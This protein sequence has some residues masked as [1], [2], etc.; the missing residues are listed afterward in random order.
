ME[1]NQFRKGWV[2]F[3][4]PLFPVIERKMN[5]AKR[6]LGKKFDSLKDNTSGTPGKE[7]HRDTGPYNLH[8]SQAVV[9]LKSP[10]TFH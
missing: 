2:G 10:K 8:L 4:L 5:L 1:N 3:C 6:W 9:V 7:S